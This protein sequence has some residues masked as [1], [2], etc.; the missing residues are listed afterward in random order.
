MRAP[1]A[2]AVFIKLESVRTPADA[3]L[4][5]AGSMQARAKALD[6]TEPL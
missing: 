5:I 6:K 3:G 2:T 1:L 4:A